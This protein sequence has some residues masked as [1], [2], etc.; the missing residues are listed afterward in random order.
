MIFFRVSFSFIL[1]ITS[2][3][4]Q[5]YL[6][7]TAEINDRVDDLLSRMT[8]DEKVGQMTQPG[9]AFLNSNNDI[10][11]YFLG[12][13][14]SGGGSSPNPNTAQSWA[15]MYDQYQNQALSTRLKIPLIYGVDAVHGH[16]NVSGA[17]IFPH[18]IGL[19][20]TRNPELIK[21]AA[22]ITAKEV[23]ATGIDW[24]FAPCIA[25]PR[26]E[27]W[28]RTYEGFG[29]TAELAEMFATPSIVGYQSDD[30]SKNTSIL[31]CAK[32]FI[33]DGGTTNGIDQGN[34][35]IDEETLRAIHLPGYLKAIEAGIGSVMSS[36]SSWNGSKLH[37]NY[38][39]LT[40][41]LKEEL[42]FDGFVVSDWAGIDQLPGDY[43]SDIKG[44]IN[45]GIDMVMVPENYVEFITLLK[46]L[47]NENQISQAR[48]DDAVKRILRIKFM[49]GLFENPL[50][51]RSLLS[52]VGSNEHRQVAREC[53]RESI[54]LLK[55]KDNILPLKKSNQ[56]IAV[57]GIGA[58][59]IGLQSGGWTIYWQGG[60]GDIT[61][62]TT[63]L[64][65][66]NK[67]TN[68][69]NVIYSKNGENI[70]GADIAVIVLAEEPYAEYAGF[71]ED[72]TIPAKDIEL[73]KRAK[74][75]GLK[76]IVVLY[77]GRPMIINPILKY[78]DAILAAWLPGTE[79]DGITDILF[80][81]FQPTGKLPHTWPKYMDQI[82]INI[83]DAEYDPMFEYNFG[84]TSTANSEF[85]SNPIFHSSFLYGNGN[86]LELSFNKAINSASI[87]NASF[88]LKGENN[89]IANSTSV[90]AASDSNT[91]II[92]FDNSVTSDIKLSLDYISGNIAS[93]DGG[94]LS[95][96]TNAFVYNGLLDNESINIAPGIIEAENFISMEGIQTQETSDAGGGE[97]VGWIDSGD[98]MEY[99]I[100]V[101]TTGTYR[102]NYRV[103]SE[104]LSGIIK[105][106]EGSNNISTTL[107]PITG[108]W[109]SWQ[110]ISTEV[111][112]DKGIK[113]YRLTAESGGFNLNWF[114]FDLLVEVEETSNEITDFELS[115]NYPNPFNPS[116]NI[117]VQIP[118]GSDV[119]L[120]VFNSNGEL[121]RELYKGFLSKGKYN[122][123]FNAEN[124]ASGIYLYKL[125][126]DNFQSIK[127]MI[128]IK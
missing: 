82:P 57:V 98:W 86:R 21:L 59:N 85:G 25:V 74:E 17:V 117:T 19:G 97:N 106:S 55:K 100:D 64:E 2:L 32:H 54:V 69:E 81:D 45:A 78:S 50:T 102:L 93:V 29:E 76:T 20:A 52:S 9:R 35:E 75:K 31:A 105:L 41:V 49:M 108:N 4:G 12:S 115:Q 3:I 51:D 96:F 77:S 60:S 80:G 120:N 68:N 109:Q 114:S 126:T 113:N 122:F 66:I 8:I 121:I 118:N 65:A 44:S 61:E 112:L 99:Q 63:L 58:D 39:L 37:G 28:G 5:V 62:G 128:F 123:R 10:K 40:T 48:I 18:N 101:L 84:L 56:K 1:L 53:V 111:S 107:L 24:T 16:N 43:K 124:I 47:I 15:D 95:K 46:E 127:K 30:L 14:L 116:T 67:N 92:D 33:G 87:L 42:G 34:T 94:I 104:S 73:V 13:L 79:G 7:P 36:Y 72:L 27:K 6:D 22:E 89:F 38:Y 83:G 26:N 70:D 110:T 90:S 125:K 88:T 23:A 91:I 103:A 119:E 11:N 71:K